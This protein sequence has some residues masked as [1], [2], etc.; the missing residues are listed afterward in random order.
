LHQHRGSFFKLPRSAV[1]SQ[2]VRQSPKLYH[3]D[4]RKDAQPVL[5]PMICQAQRKRKGKATFLGSFDPTRNMC[6]MCTIELVRGI[7]TSNTISFRSLSGNRNSMGAIGDHPGEATHRIHPNSTG[8]HD[9]DETNTVCIVTQ[10]M[11]YT[12]TRL[13]RLARCLPGRSCCL[14]PR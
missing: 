2:Q 6:T 12:L 4:K 8:V 11:Y 5:Q 10:D 13:E 1:G 14:R 3:A 7:Q 9:M